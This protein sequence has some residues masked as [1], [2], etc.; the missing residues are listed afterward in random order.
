ME[1]NKKQKIIAIVLVFLVIIVLLINLFKSDDK[2][3]DTSI[4]LL[5]DRNRF[6][7]VSNSVDKFIKYVSAQDEDSISK[8]IN[9]EYMK[10]NNIQESNIL[11]IVP[12]INGNYVFN[13]T[14]IY[15]QQ[16]SENVYKY[17]VKG[18]YYQ[19]TI[20]GSGQKNDYYTIVY[21]YTNSMT[22]SIEPYDGTVFEG[23]L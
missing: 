22:F 14:R 13:A 15:E 9:K 4:N 7:E 6:F 23:D 16:L 21:F 8:I 20:D 11:S 2:K 19:E 5:N 17:Y 10:D 18:Y 12:N 3:I 1:D